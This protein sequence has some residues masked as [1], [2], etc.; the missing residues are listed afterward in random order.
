MKR[1]VRVYLQDMHD[2]MLKALEYT[3]GLDYEAFAADSKT[4]YAVVR[5]LEIIGEAAKNVPEQVRNVYPE[6]PWRQMAG[7]R[8][9]IAH[10]YF[11]VQLKTVWRVVKEDIPGLVDKI[12]KACETAPEKI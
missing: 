4:N 3:A 6:I 2:S 12:K 7:M 11:G 1:N 8:K 10:H 9:K 5:C